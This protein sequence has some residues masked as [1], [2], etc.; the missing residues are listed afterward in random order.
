MPTKEGGQGDHLFPELYRLA[1]L[2]QE[3]NSF[4][5]L[6]SLQQHTSSYLANLPEITATAPPGHDTSV[7]ALITDT[8]TNHSTHEQVMPKSTVCNYTQELSVE[9]L[10]RDAAM[11]PINVL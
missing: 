9:M 10:G 2:N 7:T 1:F 4:T 5:S 11:Q 3:L 8:R 6:W